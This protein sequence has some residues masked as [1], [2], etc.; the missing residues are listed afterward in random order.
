MAL[1]ADERRVLDDIER[2]LRREDP[3]LVAG[4]D[5]LAAPHGRL[6]RPMPARRSRLW[7][8]LQWVAGIVVAVVFPV[9]LAGALLLGQFVAALVIAGVL[10]VTVGL[11]LQSRWSR[12]RP[13]RRRRF[14]RWPFRSG[15]TG[16]DPAGGRQ[17]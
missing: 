2:A 11:L 3:E 10:P 13:G 17:G 7:A 15:G 4:F 5:A 14:R 16:G 12:R 8:A 6:K 1:S 9:L